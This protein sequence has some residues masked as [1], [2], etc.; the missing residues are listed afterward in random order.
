MIDLKVQSSRRLCGKRSNNV[1][2]ISSI[3]ELLPGYARTPFGGDIKM[4]CLNCDH[5]SDESDGLEYGPPWYACNKK[6]NMS[7]LNGFPFKTPL[8]CWS[9]PW[10]ATVDWDAEV[11]KM[12]NEEAVCRHLSNGKCWSYCWKKCEFAAPIDE[13]YRKC[14]IIKTLKAMGE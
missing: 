7:N 11:R 6:P 12:A 1:E 8:K 10:Q 2:K 14:E 4:E 9:T 3:E 13:Y 5:I